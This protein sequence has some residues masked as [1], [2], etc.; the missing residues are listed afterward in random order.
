MWLW[1]LLLFLLP[2]GAYVS[3][4]A[5]V[6]PPADEIRQARTV[7]D[8]AAQAYRAVPALKDTLTYTISG[9]GAEPGSKR[10]S[11]F[12]GP[13]KDVS[14][15]DALFQAT[16]V[17][18]MFYLT[19]SGAT[20]RYLARP[21]AGNF[22]AT[23]ES[24]SGSLFVPA[25]VAMRLGGD[26]ESCINALRF[27]Q[28]SPL[29]IAGC[30]RATDARGRKVDALSFVADNGRLEATFDSETHFFSAIHL[31]FQ[32]AGAPKDVTIEIQGEF[33]PQA[34]DAAAGTIVF[35][36]GDR[37]PV[38]DLTDLDSEILPTGKAAP[39]FVLATPAGQSFELAGFEGARGGGGF[40]GYLVCALL[41]VPGRGAAARRLGRHEQSAGVRTGHQHT[42][43]ICHGTRAK[44]ARCGVV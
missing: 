22:T 34:L 39:N 9:P 33:A 28:L 37:R 32:P 31:T 11:I 40:L 21:Y 18:Q 24:L 30:R 26:R 7:L 12:L 13:G 36:P 42:G 38:A 5:E 20:N 8:A 4:G 41:G 14:V 25:E 27:R 1:I 17:G 23:L 10:V 43:K 16:A 6:Q 29:R 2:S 15:G 35:N 19:K 3:A 44:Y